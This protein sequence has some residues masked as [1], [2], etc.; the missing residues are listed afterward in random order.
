MRTEGM[1]RRGVG[2]G[3]LLLGLLA[4]LV[5]GCAEEE[6]GLSQK[7]AGPAEGRILPELED[8]YRT[9]VLD[10]DHAWVVGSRGVILHLT[11]NGENVELLNS[12]VEKAFYDVNF[13]DPQNGIVVGQEGTL[14]KTTDGGKS[15]RKISIELHLEDWQKALPHFFGLSRGADPNKIW[16]VG[17]VGTI[18]RSRDGGETWENITLPAPPEQFGGRNWDLTLN[19]VYFADD[20]EGWIVGEFGKILHTTD[21]GDNWERQ[22]NVLNLPKFTR[23][24]LS[25]E[26][27]LKRR[28]PELHLEDL[29][30]LGVSFLDN[31]RGFVAAE[32]GIL[33][34]TVDGGAT[35]TNVSSGS[36]NTLL[37]VTAVRRDG[38]SLTLASGVLGTV[39]RKTDSG[40][41]T[42]LSQVQERVLTWIRSTSFDKAGDFGVACGGKGTILLTGDGGKNWTQVPSEK[43]QRLAV[44]QSA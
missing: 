23:P 16:V 43:L 11:N 37:S 32:S 40:G 8:Y 1:R 42:F 12:G 25:E 41:W 35:W 24:E 19:G 26:E 22:V 28:V 17:P 3:V 36:F 5:A 2:A 27:A 34:E 4:V 30:I 44:G 15:W 9:F 20:N 18:L 29:Y 13:V 38:S 10:A 33:L 6:T 21:G 7:L 14:L 31:D 39:A